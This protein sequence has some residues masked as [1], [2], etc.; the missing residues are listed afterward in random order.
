MFIIAGSFVFT[1]IWLV[2]F[3]WKIDV[4]NNYKVNDNSDIDMTYMEVI[5]FNPKFSVCKIYF[6]ITDKTSGENKHGIWSLIPFRE[7]RQVIFK[8]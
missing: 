7:I 6:R 2:I 3:Q 5:T 1:L 8:M 4:K